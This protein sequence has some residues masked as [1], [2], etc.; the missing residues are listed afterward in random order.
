MNDYIY[1]I[2][3]CVEQLA[4]VFIIRCRHWFSSLLAISF[5]VEV[6][7][8]TI[9]EMIRLTDDL[10]AKILQDIVNVQSR[11][12]ELQENNCAVRAT[13][14]RDHD[15]QSRTEQSIFKSNEARH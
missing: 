5:P 4:D 11:I 6:R 14:W 7:R 10:R 1:D 9:M 13:Y 15:D 12:N 2:G 3:K 8:M